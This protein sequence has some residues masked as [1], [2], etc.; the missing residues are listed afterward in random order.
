MCFLALWLP[1]RAAFKAEDFKSCADSAFCGRLRGVRQPEY[2]VRPDSVQLTD[3]RLTATLVDTAADKDFALTLTAYDGTLRVHVTEPG[4]R[5]YEVQDVLLDT[6][7]PAALTRSEENAEHSVLT[8]SGHEARLHYAPFRLE[9]PGV[10][11]L[12]ARGLF[13]IEH[14]RAKP[15]ANAT[16]GEWEETFKGH[17]DSKPRGPQALSFDLTFQGF[18]HVY[19]LPE[20]ATDFALPPTAGDGVTTSDPYRL[21]NLDV[22]EYL[23]RS[24]FGLYGSIPY[25]TAHRAGRTMGAFWLNAAE[26]YVDVQRAAGGTE[27]QWWAESGVVDVFLMLGPSPA[28]VAAQYAALTG[29]SALPQMFSTGYHQCRCARARRVDAVLRRVVCMR[30]GRPLGDYPRLP[31]HSVCRKAIREADRRCL[32]AVKLQEEFCA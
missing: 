8:V 18:A 5:R 6:A 7:A 16:R 2:R 19:G 12:N 13:G 24:P 26:M 21:Y 29:T 23:A 31:A 20:H 1:P 9:V 30:L 14:A 11:T 17:T 15:T 10:L 27:T 3:G 32:E 22:F 4:A 28:A 25:L